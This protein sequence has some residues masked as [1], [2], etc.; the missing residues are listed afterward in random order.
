VA[1][2]LPKFP[3]ESLPSPAKPVGY[4]LSSGGGAQ[5]LGY[6]PKMPWGWYLMGK[7]HRHPAPFGKGEA[8][9]CS[10]EGSG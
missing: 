9:G 8:Q 7:Q 5:C 6:F 3:V 2:S 4:S 10:V 1:P